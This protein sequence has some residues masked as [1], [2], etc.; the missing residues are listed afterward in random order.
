M[1][2][3]SELEAISDKIRRGES[4][5]LAEAIAAAEYQSRQSRTIPWWNI[6]WNKICEV[7]K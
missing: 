5:G 4:V 1:K 2:S 7:F 6:I 3:Q